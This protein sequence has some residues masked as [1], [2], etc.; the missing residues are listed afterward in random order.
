MD[1]VWEIAIE[2]RENLHLHFGFSVFFFIS[3]ESF[4]RY[5][6]LGG[7][8]YKEFLFTNFTNEP[9]E[10]LLK[11]KYV[12]K[13]PISF[14]AFTTTNVSCSSNVFFFFA[15]SLFMPLL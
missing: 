13:E 11:F 10:H 7:I 4:N 1:L 9:S 3:N 2:A 8:I 5:N 6:R 15:H 12:A 14:I